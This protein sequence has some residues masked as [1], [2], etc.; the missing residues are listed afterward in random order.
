LRPTEIQIDSENNVYV[1][2]QSDKKIK[3]FSTNG[4]LLAKLGPG[5]GRGPGEF[6]LPFDFAIDSTGNFYVVDLN[7]RALISL[8]SKGNYRWQKVFKHD[9]PTRVSAGDSEIILSIS[10]INSS[11]PFKSFRKDGTVGI[12]YNSLFKYTG[13]TDLPAFVSIDGKATVGK[14]ISYSAGKLIF[15]PRFL[16]HLIF[17]DRRGSVDFVVETID[18]VP[19]PQK[20]Y[21][22]EM[23]DLGGGKK[24]PNASFS[25]KAG[26]L[27]INIIDNFLIVWSKTG[28]KEFGYQTF[29]VYS[30]HNGKYLYSFMVK[31]L[32]GISDV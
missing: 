9:S 29:D 19:I 31:E 20:K 15:A 22:D 21:S 30:L 27:D 18:Q 8:D 16:S 12:R 23:I 13:D 1:L 24:M 7:R 5:S 28:N 17:F 32:G 14:F 6:I 25:G 26:S 10:G 4:N 3:K 11:H 2:D